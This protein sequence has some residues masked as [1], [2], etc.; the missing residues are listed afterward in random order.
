MKASLSCSTEVLEDNHVH[1]IVNIE[2]DSREAITRTLLNLL[3]E[4]AKKGYGNEV[5]TAINYVIK[6]S[7]GLR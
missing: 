4:L 6:S 1:V 3:A 5:S 2:A 7:R